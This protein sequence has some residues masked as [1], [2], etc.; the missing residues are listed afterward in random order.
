MKNKYSSLQFDELAFQQL[1]EANINI[2]DAAELSYLARKGRT[3]TE[4]ERQVHTNNKDFVRLG[5]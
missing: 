5:K 2:Q 3:L 4:D 1:E